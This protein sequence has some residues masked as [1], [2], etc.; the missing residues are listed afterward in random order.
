MTK[1]AGDSIAALNTR[2]AAETPFQFEATGPDGKPSGHW[3]KVLGGQSE[4]VVK[5][6]NALINARRREEAE[7]TA[8]AATGRP[9]DNV[10]PVEDDIAFGQRLSAVRLVG[11]RGPEESDDLTPEEKQRFRGI[12]DG[13]TPELALILCQ[14]NPDYA[15]QVLLQSNKT[16]NFTKASSTGS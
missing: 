6:S 12:S 3:L 10:T 5:A 4:T 8:Q 7:R 14:T 2:K 15:A 16:A 13:Y 11:W 1:N 9:G